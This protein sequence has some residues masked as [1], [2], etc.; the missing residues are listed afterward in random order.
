MCELQCVCVCETVQTRS[1]S[2]TTPVGAI[3]NAFFAS[4][5]YRRLAIVVSAFF[6]F[7]PAINEAT[8]PSNRPGIAPM[9]WPATLS[10]DWPLSFAF[11]SFEIVASNSFVK[12]TFEIKFN[13]QLIDRMISIWNEFNF[14]EICQPRSSAG[15]WMC[16]IRSTGWRWRWSIWRS[17]R[18]QRLFSFRPIGQRVAGHA[19]QV[20]L[21][22]GAVPVA[23][24]PLPDAVVDYET[25][26][27]GGGRDDDR[28]PPI[29]YPHHHHYHHLLLLLLMLML[30][31]LLS[32]FQRM[33][34]NSSV[35]MLHQEGTSVD[36]QEKS[37]SIFVA[38]ESTRP[39]VAGVS[40][41][42]KEGGDA[43]VITVWTKKTR[44][45]TIDKDTL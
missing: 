23:L 3:R 20:W 34:W 11:V 41:D 22:D 44:L 1:R 32:N 13:C 29:H 21:D 37:F 45:S 31:L 38:V 10:L 7:H 40:N 39:V 9:W 24:C 12:P 16:N 2:N 19:G 36:Y 33:A 6:T 15:R 35:S 18:A 17:N 28:T 14:L 27:V 8:L 26:V 42:I 30:L 4:L 5:S 43:V 25:D